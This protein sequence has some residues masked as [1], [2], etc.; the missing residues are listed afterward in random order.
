MANKAFFDDSPKF[1]FEVFHDRKFANIRLSS[2]DII[3]VAI[4]ARVL[5]LLKKKHNFSCIPCHLKEEF[6]LEI[7]EEAW[8]AL[9]DKEFDLTDEPLPTGQE[10]IPIPPEHMLKDFVNGYVIP[11]GVYSEIINLRRSETDFISQYVSARW[12]LRVPGR[13]IAHVIDHW[14]EQIAQ[15]DPFVPPPADVRR[16]P[17]GGVANVSWRDQPIFLFEQ[18]ATTVF[19]STDLHQR[20]RPANCFAA[21]T[22]R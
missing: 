4:A 5:Y 22:E 8:E 17:P 7:S 2:G 11:S 14:S 21:P 3:S 20:T 16:S 15:A 6:N 13:V 18:S 10:L 1:E 12:G 19:T 9:L